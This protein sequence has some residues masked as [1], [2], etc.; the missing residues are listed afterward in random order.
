[1]QNTVYHYYTDCKQNIT[2]EGFFSTF[3]NYRK[4]QLHMIDYLGF[5]SYILIVMGEIDQKIVIV[6]VGTTTITHENGEINKNIM[7]N[8]VNQV[9]ILKEKGWLVVIVSS[10]AIGCG[11]RI[12][13]LDSPPS[14]KELST[15]Q[16]CAAVGQPELMKK[17]KKSFSNKS[18]VSQHLVTSGVFKFANNLIAFRECIYTALKMGVVPIVNENDAVSTE[19]ID[20]Q[21]TDNDSLSVIVASVLRAKKLVLLSDIDGLFDKNPFKN[22]DAKLIKEVERV[23]ETISNYADGKSN[24]GRGGMDGKLHS[25]DIAMNSGVDVYLTNGY[26][27]DCILNIFTNNFSGTHFKAH[28]H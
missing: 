1:L 10:G 7:Q 23:D 22:K 8:I 15:R 17:W 21:F 5:F 3:P 14:D 12:L 27:K 18:I 16:V 6:K 20:A 4:K 2:V 26:K 13:G 19:E 11:I 28:H 25:I 24:K 9:Q